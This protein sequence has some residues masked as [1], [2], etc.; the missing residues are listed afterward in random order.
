[1]NIRKAF[2]TAIESLVICQVNGSP[3]SSSVFLSLKKVW[4][5]VMQE[6]SNSSADNAL[7]WTALEKLPWL[8]LFR[9]TFKIL[10]NDFSCEVILNLLFDY[11]N[12]VKKHKTMKQF[13]Q[14]NN[15]HKFILNKCKT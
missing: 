15:D 4:R 7:A 11:G 13:L 10:F 3:T 5:I 1:M 12:E 2:K 14:Y 8:P 9:Q 6:P